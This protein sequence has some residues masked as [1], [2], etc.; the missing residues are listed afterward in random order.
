MGLDAGFCQQS[1][2]E[3]KKNNKKYS[4]GVKGEEREVRAAAGA[5]HAAGAD[6]SMR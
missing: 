5:R 4:S 6:G 2:S 1:Q 3:K